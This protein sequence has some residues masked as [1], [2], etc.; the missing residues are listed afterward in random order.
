MSHR[1]IGITRPEVAARLEASGGLAGATR[2]SFVTSLG[3]AAVLAPMPKPGFFLFQR[4]RALRE[5]VELQRILEALAAVGPLLPAR[6]STRLEDEGEALELICGNAARLREALQAYGSARQ[7]QVTVTWDARA[8]VAAIKHRADVVEGLSRAAP[9]GRLAAGKFLQEIM[10]GE[11]E[12]L[13]R[14]IRERLSK[15]AREVAE[16]PQDGTDCVANLVLLIEADAESALDSALAELDRL[17]PGDSRI[18]CVGP[19]PALSFAAVSLER[20]DP[21]RIDAARRLLG[22]GH[23]LSCES[24]QTAWRA[25]ARTHHPDAGCAA[26]AGE[27]TDAATAY[28]LL[29]RFAEETERAGTAPALFVDITGQSDAG[30][31]A[32]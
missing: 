31:R 20:I 11:R 21:D 7:F 4:Q 19:L 1:L 13:A 29:R 30:R 12:K 6:P 24:V 15:V 2:L 5:L 3:L 23:R 18:R 9:R 8:M 16:M 28:H 26:N 17:L 22:V 32:A 25:Y 10:V 14:E 27:F